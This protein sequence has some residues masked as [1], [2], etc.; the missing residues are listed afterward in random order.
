MV[1]KMPTIKSIDYQTYRSRTLKKE[2]PLLAFIYSLLLGLFYFT[3]KGLFYLEYMTLA[4]IFISTLILAFFVEKKMYAY[5]KHLEFSLPHRI[6]YVIILALFP[7]IY[8]GLI[9]ISVLR[10]L[11]KHG[12]KQV[13]VSLFAFNIICTTLIAA[14]MEHNNKLQ[15][16]VTGVRKALNPSLHFVAKIAQEAN[17]MFELKEQVTKKCATPEIGCRTDRLNAAHTDNLTST[18]II[19]YTAVS[20]M[21]IFK[22]KQDLEKVKSKK[23]IEMAAIK[24]L[25]ESTFVFQKNYCNNNPVDNM[26]SPYSILSP[27]AL[28]EYSLLRAIDDIMVSRF[29]HIAVP[30]LEEIHAKV[31]QDKEFT[32]LLGNRLN[33]YNQSACGQKYRKI[34]SIFTY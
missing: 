18:G 14:T 12:F 16:M 24:K 34:A 23:L 2:L 33:N 21:A 6:F 25:T 8:F 22:E 9:F 20:A 13:V 30:K 32:N 15:V 4:T 7:F 26:F 28:I 1:M 10:P 17:Y 3:N 11:T 27:I 29:I 19:L 5:L 31:R